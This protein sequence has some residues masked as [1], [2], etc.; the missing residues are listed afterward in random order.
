MNNK[1]E[2][3]NKL[4]QNIDSKNQNTIPFFREW[5]IWYINMWVNIWY[6]ED[7]KNI[8]YTRPI[9]IIK[10]FSKDTFLWIPTTTSEKIWKYYYDI[11]I[12]WNKNNYLIL[13][14]IRLFSSKRLVSHIWWISLIN[15]K[16][17]KQKINK[18]IE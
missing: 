6:E 10:K 3:W 7:W 11:W 9:L 13:S 2:N 1:F 8:D 14:Q 17:I 5:Q 15:L 16:D 4:K 18:L 12:I